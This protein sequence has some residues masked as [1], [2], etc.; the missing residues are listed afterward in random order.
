MFI[1]VLL[2]VWTT[3]MEKKWKKKRRDATPFLPHTRE[4]I[5]KKTKKK[6]KTKKRTTD[7]PFDSS[8]LSHHMGKNNNTTNGGGEEEE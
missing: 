1:F 6:T 8:F 7:R 4:R 5:L 2:R 3:L